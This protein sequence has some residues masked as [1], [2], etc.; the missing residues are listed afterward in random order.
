LMAPTSLPVPLAGD[1]L[2][3]ARD[4]SDKDADAADYIGDGENLA[5]GGFRHEIAVAESGDGHHAPVPRRFSLSGADMF[6]RGSRS[7]LW[8]TSK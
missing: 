6:I 2:A 5:C 4:R 1:V 3:E 7:A 8:E